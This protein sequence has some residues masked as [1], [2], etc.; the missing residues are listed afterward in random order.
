[1]EIGETSGY[2]RRSREWHPL[3]TEEVARSVAGSAHSI[4]F[5][6]RESD[7]RVEV[8]GYYPPLK[9]WVAVVVIPARRPLRNILHNGYVE[10][11][12]KEEIRKRAR[13]HGWR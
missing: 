2:F 8:F 4:V 7:G 6:P 13:R 5:P 3:I 10:W 12:H 11:H 9:A 1:M